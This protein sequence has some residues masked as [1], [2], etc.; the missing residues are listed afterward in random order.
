[1]TVE[2]YNKCKWCGVSNIQVSSDLECGRCWEIRIACEMDPGLVH[3]IL[4]ASER[5]W[6]KRNFR[7]V[8]Q[9]PDRSD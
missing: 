6:F 3:R 7:L 9:R 2:T 1:M 4:I 8:Q 5:E